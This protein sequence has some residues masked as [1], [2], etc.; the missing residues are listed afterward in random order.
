MVFSMCAG[1]TEP[2][3]VVTSEF[4]PFQTEFSVQIFQVTNGCWVPENGGERKTCYRSSGVKAATFLRLHQGVYQDT[5]II[6]V[7]KVGISHWLDSVIS[8]FFSRLNDS[9]IIF[10]RVHHPS[11]PISVHLQGHSSFSSKPLGEVMLQ[12]DPKAPFSLLQLPIPAQAPGTTGGGVMDLHVFPGSM[13]ALS[14]GLVTEIL[15]DCVGLT[16]WEVI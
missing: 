10:H 8:E 4:D 13:G 2:A 16:Q 7:N 5:P 6:P 15:F 9:V 1:D 12:S 3:P 11:A 14:V